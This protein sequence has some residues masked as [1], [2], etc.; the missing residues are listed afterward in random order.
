VQPINYPTV[1][2]GTERLRLTLN[3]CEHVSNVRSNVRIVHSVLFE[4]VEK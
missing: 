2:L 3:A 4:S 1:P